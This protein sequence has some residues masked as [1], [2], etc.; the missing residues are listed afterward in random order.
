MRQKDPYANLRGPVRRIMRMIEKRQE[1]HDKEMEKN[2]DGR[3][4]PLYTVSELKKDYPR[5]RKK[6]EGSRRERSRGASYQFVYRVLEFLEEEGYVTR[7]EETDSEGRK[8]IYF[9]TGGRFEP[10]VLAIQPKGKQFYHSKRRNPQKRYRTEP[11]NR[12]VIRC[13]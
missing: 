3:I 9:R 4:T 6:K 7:L 5:I 10:K 8:R 12:N 1:Q 13:N 11:R 2:P